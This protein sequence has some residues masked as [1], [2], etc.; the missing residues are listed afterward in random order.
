ME[1]DAMISH[2][3]S[4]FLKERLVD[5]SDIYTCY[6][7]SKC[8]LIASKKM[9]KDIYICHACN[10]LPENQGETAYAHKVVMPYAFKLLVQELMAI[11]ILPRIRVKGD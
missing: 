5:T 4:L 11:N 8:G 9:D 3:C 6:V 10:K 2:G 1:R 7:C